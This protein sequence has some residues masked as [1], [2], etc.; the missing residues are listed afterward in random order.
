MPCFVVGRTDLTQLPF[1]RPCEMPALCQAFYMSNP[2][3]H[4]WPE[5]PH[6]L[7]RRPGAVAELSLEPL[8]TQLWPRQQRQEAAASPDHGV[9]QR[10]R[11]TLVSNERVQDIRRQKTR[12]GGPWALGGVRRTD[13]REVRDDRLHKPG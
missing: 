7:H 5:K 4:S 6:P 3:P 13:V 1:I 10:G 2:K 9:R 12:M 11:E 8:V